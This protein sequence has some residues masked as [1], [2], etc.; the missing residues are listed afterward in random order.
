[1]SCVRME[2]LETIDF[3]KV[4]RICWPSRS[5]LQAGWGHKLCLQW[6]QLLCLPGSLQALPWSGVWALPRLVDGQ[7]SVHAGLI[8]ELL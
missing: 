8:W 7:S 4:P 6:G 5:G 1:M 3:Q 2:S